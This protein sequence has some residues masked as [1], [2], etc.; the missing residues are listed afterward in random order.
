MTLPFSSDRVEFVSEGDS[1]ALMTAVAQRAAGVREGIFGPESA[2]W[3]VNREAAV[4]LGA[5]RAAWLQLAHP[6]VAA[7]LEQHPLSPPS[8]KG[9][10]KDGVRWFAA[11]RGGG[12]QF[13]GDARTIEAWI[14]ATRWL[15]S[16]SIH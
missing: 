3:K 1:Q 11:C 9:R 13:T 14:R 8:G 2:S 7:A 4:F 6:W 12:I 10:L 5:G 16:R 15:P